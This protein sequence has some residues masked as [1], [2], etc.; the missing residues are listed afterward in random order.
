[1]DPPPAPVVPPGTPWGAPPPYVIQPDPVTG[2]VVV[3]QAMLDGGFFGALLGFRSESVVPGGVVPDNGAGTAVSA[4]NQRNGTALNVYFEAEGIGG[5]YSFAQ[6][7]VPLYVNN[8]PEVRLLNLQQFIGGA[9]G[10]CTGLTDNLDVLY[11][12]DH[13]LTSPDWQLKITSASGSAPGIVIPPYP[14]TTTAR[15]DA[16]TLSY[17][18]TAWNHCSYL[19]TFSS[20]RMLTTGIVNDDWNESYLTFCH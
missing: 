10:A 14:G 16:G 20:R 19:V 15:G 9:A 7:P 2:W 11:T 4:A 3:D 13:E 12:L 18:I 6:L 17:V 1:V 8:W 5:A